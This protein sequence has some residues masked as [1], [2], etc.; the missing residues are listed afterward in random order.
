MRAYK[1]MSKNATMALFAAGFIS[2]GAIA[3]IGVQSFAQTPDAT[4]T[5]SSHVRGLMDFMDDD[6]NN[7]AL[8]S[9]GI[10]EVQATKAVTAL[11]PSL[12]I[13]HI[14]LEDENG[15]ILYSTKL[16]DGTEAIVDVVTSAVSLETDEQEAS[17]HQGTGRWHMGKDETND[18]KVDDDS[19][20]PTDAG[21]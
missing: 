4:P 20:G 17:E 12:T 8:P 9:G 7:V 14:R 21:V 10:S 18:T 1:R 6:D 11:Y 19:D 2:T 16:S 5:T 13:K 15:A 3:S